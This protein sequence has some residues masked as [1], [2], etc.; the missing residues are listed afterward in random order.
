V[1]VASASREAKA[2]NVPRAPTVPDRR[3]ADLRR[4]GTLP[5]PLRTPHRAPEPSREHISHLVTQAQQNDREAFGQLYRLYF[6]RLYNLARFYLPQQAEDIVAETF[7][8]A[9]AAI[10]R[11]RDMN[12]P[13]VVWLYAIARHIVSDEL[14]A[15]RRVEPRSEIPEEPREWEHDD[16]IMLATALTR[17]PLGQ[18]RVIELRYLLGMTHN[19]IAVILRK[20]VGAV[21]AQRWRALQ[22]LS[23]ILTSR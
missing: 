21:K 5:R 19:E 1:D 23:T 22:N 2:A 13:F 18:R 11:Y 6:H 4:R 15:R 3:D 16:R 20:S 14:K 7:L 17:L 12:R 8:R 9:W 10:G